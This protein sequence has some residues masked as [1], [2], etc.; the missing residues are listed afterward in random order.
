MDRLKHHLSVLSEMIMIDI[1][2]LILGETVI[3]TFVSSSKACAVGFLIGVIITVFNTIYIRYM[4][5]KTLCHRGKTAVM[6][7][8]V[9]YVIRLIFTA[10]IFYAMYVWKIGDPLAGLIG[11]FSLK[12]SAYL[13][14]FIHKIL[15][16]LMKNNDSCNNNL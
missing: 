5:K 13:Q 7:S 14:P 3:I 4:I 11:M 16:K 6:M 12:I 1:I 8:V 2:Y 10:A 9:S 15:N